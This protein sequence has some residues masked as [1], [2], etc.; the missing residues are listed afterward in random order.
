[1]DTFSARKKVCTSDINSLGLNRLVKE[2]DLLKQ[3]AEIL[4]GSDANVSAVCYKIM[5]QVQEM[6]EGLQTLKIIVGKQEAQLE[7]CKV[8]WHFLNLNS[9]FR[10]I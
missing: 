5:V 3:A 8:L 6:K 10:P 2:A 7:T 4:E 1:M 9:L